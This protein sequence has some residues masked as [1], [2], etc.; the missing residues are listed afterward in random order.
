MKNMRKLLAGCLAITLCLS[1]LAACGDTTGSN[2]SSQGTSQTG[3]VV[4]L[5]VVDISSIIQNPESKDPLE[6]SSMQSEPTS[7]GEGGL[8]SLGAEFACLTLTTEEFSTYL[9]N[10]ADWNTADYDRTD[11]QAAS[12]PLG[13][14]V[15]GSSPIGWGG[16]GQ[17][18]HGLL[19]VTTFEVEDLT[20]LEGK[21][22]KMYGFYD[23]TIYMYLNGNLIYSDD[24]ALT[25]QN[26]WIDTYE[27]KEFAEDISPYLVEGTNVLAVSLLDGW[28]GR[29]L[30]ISIV[31]K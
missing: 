2:T 22:Y 27:E 26:D 17:E 5:P 9:T 1:G 18:P 25:G 13:D 14:R 19:A 11:W 30:D 31:E 4:S 15:N 23:N 6:V 3:S 10:H 24:T 28:G 29:E 21:E 20:A 16:E 8:V 7:A 12:A